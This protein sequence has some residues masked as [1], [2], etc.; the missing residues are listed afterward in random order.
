[1]LDFHDLSLLIHF[2]MRHCCLVRGLFAQVIAIGFYD[3]KTE[4]LS[5][6]HFA[7]QRISDEVKVNDTQKAIEDA[8]HSHIDS[9]S[10]TSTD[11]ESPF[12]N[13]DDDG[14]H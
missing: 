13:L 8:I 1:M 6:D 9:L 7:I 3:H 5:L 12:S 11:S 2:P 4:D 10:N 14:T